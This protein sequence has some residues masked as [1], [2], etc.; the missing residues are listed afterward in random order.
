MSVEYEHEY[1]Q[2]QKE[3]LFSLNILGQKHFDAGFH[4]DLL[5]RDS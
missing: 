3:L 1:E 4:S 2:E 5:E